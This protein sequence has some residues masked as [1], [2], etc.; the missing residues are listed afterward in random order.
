MSKTNR[1]SNG[2][3]SLEALYSRM[4]KIDHTQPWPAFR[5]P[6]VE[7]TAMPSLK[8]LGLAGLGVGGAGALGAAGGAALTAP[9]AG[10]AGYLAGHKSGMKRDAET[11]YAPQHMRYALTR[12]RQYGRAEVIHAL[13]RRA[14][15]AQQIR[16]GRSPGFSTKVKKAEAQPFKISEEALEAAAYVQGM[17]KSAH[18]NLQI[19][20]DV[21]GY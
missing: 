6:S 5:G 1:V 8:Q 7:K 13:R 14:M 18:V 16:Q 11:P 15:A 20:A 9:I 17:R 21:R 2:V 3:K 10:G 4:R 12:G 19:P